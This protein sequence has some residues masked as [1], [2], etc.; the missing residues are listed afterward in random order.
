MN[1]YKYPRVCRAGEVPR[2][3]V[4]LDGV[5]IDGVFECRAG[6]NGWV[7]SYR[8]PLRVVNGERI[9]E[10]PIKRGKVEIVPL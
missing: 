7:K 9:A 6:S 2:A 8:R 3:D 1:E 4:Y 10:N 5:K